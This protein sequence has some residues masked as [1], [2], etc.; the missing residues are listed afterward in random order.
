LIIIPNSLK[1]E[2]PSNFGKS[3]NDAADTVMS[4][5]VGKNIEKEIEERI[6]KFEMK[7]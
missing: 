3:L 1:G 5:E 6:K 7:K 2:L 4:G